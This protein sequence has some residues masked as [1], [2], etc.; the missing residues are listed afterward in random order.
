MDVF[1]YNEKSMI[2]CFQDSLSEV[3]LDWYMQ[4]EMIHVRTW[5]DLVDEFLKQYKYNTDMA[6]NRT[7]LQ[8]I[9]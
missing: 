9:V 5:K 1:S 7:Q 4:L 6:P 2:H 8:S 3:S